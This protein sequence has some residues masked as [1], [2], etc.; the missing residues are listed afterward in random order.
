M[1]LQNA[2]LLAF[3]RGRVSSLA[4]AR[5]D[6]KRLALSAEVQSNWLPRSLGPMSLRPGLEYIDSTRGDAQ[7]KHIP[8]VFSSSDT[9]IIEV[10]AG[11][12]R[13]RVDETVIARV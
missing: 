12:L 4:L 8:F 7:A 6:L 1:P 5:I 2:P 9:A 10:T 3:N 11:V 13:V